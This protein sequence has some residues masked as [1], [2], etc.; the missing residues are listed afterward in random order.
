[1]GD[2]SEKSQQRDIGISRGCLMSTMEG[3][4]VTFTGNHD[5][6]KASLFNIDQIS[7]L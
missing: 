2:M 7:I 6:K 3:R 1:M 5:Y 4:H